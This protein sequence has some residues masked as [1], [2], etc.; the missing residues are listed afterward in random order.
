MD[1]LI[2][3]LTARLSDAETR[4]RDLLR[5]AQG[6]RLALQEPRLLGREIPGWHSW[7]DVEAMCE[8]ALSE[9]ATWRAI[10]AQAKAG[11][12][13]DR[14]GF[15]AGFNSALGFAL[16]AKARQYSDHPDWRPDGQWGHRADP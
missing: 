12:P 11:P 15:R 9:V 2:A 1:D 7:A 14:P 6:V 8:G 5:T 10:I 4:A 13:A 3:F 16:Q